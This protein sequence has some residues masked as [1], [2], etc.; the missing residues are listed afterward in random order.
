MVLKPNGTISSAQTELF[1]DTVCVHSHLPNQTKPV[2]LLDEVS[3]DFGVVS[4][5]GKI[6]E[7]AAPNAH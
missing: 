6:Q 3:E 4:G 7:D 5:H 2:Y 1:G